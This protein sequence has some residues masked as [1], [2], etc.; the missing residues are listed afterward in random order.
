ME[1]VAAADSLLREA[2]QKLRESRAE[3]KSLRDELERAQVRERKAVDAAEEERRAGREKVA[4]LEGVV[5]KAD[6]EH[7][8]VRE[9]TEERLER[10]KLVVEEEEQEDGLQVR[11]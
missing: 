8:L 5:D 1:R 10:L 3:V 11:K 2:K 9:R 6:R 7:A 4:E